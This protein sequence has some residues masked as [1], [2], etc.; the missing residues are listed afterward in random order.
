M[1][2]HYTCSDNYICRA[3]ARSI[4]EK[5]CY[6]PCTATPCWWYSY[7]LAGSASMLWLVVS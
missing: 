3:C 1:E 5:K 7:R 4:I 2:A 6:S